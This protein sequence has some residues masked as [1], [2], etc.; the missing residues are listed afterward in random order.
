MFTRMLRIFALSLLA[1]M[2]VTGCA[3]ESE[4]PGVT[5][6]NYRAKPRA[7]GDIN[8][9]NIVAD[10]VI[11]EGPVGDS[12]RYY[13]EQAYPL[14]PQPE[15]IYDLQHLTVN[16]LDALEARRELRTYVIL[17]DIN[18]ESSPATK[19]VL[20]HL[21]EEKA[22]ATREDYKKGT[23]IVTNRWANDQLI[24]Y[25]LAQGPDK[26]GQLVAQ[27]FPAAS[28]RIAEA[29]R[30]K[31]EANIYQSG[32]ATMLP[33]SVRKF[34]GL[35][36]EIPSDYSMAVGD[37]D[38]VWLRRDLGMVI[39]NL[40]ISS[41]P[42]KDQAQLSKDSLVAYRNEMGRKAVRSS[43]PGSYMTSNDRDLP[44]L[45]N[46]TDINGAYAVEA[47]GV[48]EMTDDFMGGPYFTYAIPDQASGRLYIIDAFVYAPSKGKR[49]Y[50]Q[51]LEVIARSA[52]VEPKA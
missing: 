3:S 30:Y 32:K 1:A 22:F 25:L 9:V 33:D 40:I 11:M 28:K 51:Q 37:Q 43:T 44:V 38:Y 20:S 45:V 36:L 8:R 7:I 24:I 42:Y 41:V 48:W 35:Q 23:S 46:V 16:D 5:R 19:L 17:A 47:R 39:Q 52:K 26:L 2:L 12:I 13:Y 21:G 18:D 34:T 31:L 50:M 27:S 6:S 49:N 15:P 10:D 14:M 4:G 29:D